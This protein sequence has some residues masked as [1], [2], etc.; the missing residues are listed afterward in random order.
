MKVEK[1]DKYKMDMMVYTS[2][3]SHSFRLASEAVALPVLSNGFHIKESLVSAQHSK[4]SIFMAP[5][6]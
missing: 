2:F 5:L 1:K 3:H 6:A 4:L